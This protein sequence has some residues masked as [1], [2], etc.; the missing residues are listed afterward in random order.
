MTKFLIAF[1]LLLGSAVGASGQDIDLMW[2]EDVS[3]ETSVLKV[4]G[5]TETGHYA[6]TNRK[7]NF[8]IEHFSGVTMARDFTTQLEFEDVGGLKTELADVLYLDGQLSLLTVAFDKKVKQYHIYG[9]LLDEKG[10]ISG[11]GQ[12]ILTAQVDKGKRRGKFEI[13]HS[14]DGSKI[15]VLHSAPHRQARSNWNWEVNMVLLSSQL[16][17][18]KEIS[19]SFPLANEQDDFDVNNFIVSNAGDVYMAVRKIGFD[20]ASRMTVTKEMTI[21]QYS[22]FNGFEVDQVRVDIGDKRA[23]AIGLALDPDGNLVGGGFYSERNPRGLVR[24]EGLAGS[25]F[26][27]LDREAS[28]VSSVRLQEFGP[29]FAGKI[30]RERAAERGNLVPN[31]FIPRHII[32]RYDGGA[33]MVA[34]YYTEEVIFTRGTRTTTY[35]HGP[36][37][38]VNLNPEGA[39]DWVQVIPK[40]QVF[41]KVESAVGMTPFVW[42]VPVGYGYWINMSKDKTVYHSFMMGVKEDKI[43]LFYNDN[44][45]NVAITHNRDTRILNGWKGAVPVTVMIDGVGELSKEVLREKDRSEV[46]LRPKIHFQENYGDI[47]IYGNKRKKD[48]FGLLTY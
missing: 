48:K 17:P 41:Q 18:I 40:N 9:Y 21:Y 19:E 29:D 38:V 11:A 47:T 22:P 3:S 12:K 39:I 33:L 24:Y 13:A 27:R 44:P 8:F 35:T 30:V 20:P 28:A 46:V 45:R 10:R 23:S 43:F 2:G 7:K 15:L 16:E 36:L 26:F 1:A 31:V 42:G 25:Y 4:L 14:R 34:E 5:R 37:A 32:P 6:L